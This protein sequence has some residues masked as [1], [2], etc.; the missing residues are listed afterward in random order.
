MG[1]LPITRRIGTLDTQV[2]QNA[3]FDSSFWINAYRSG[4]LLQGVDRY[5]LHFVPAV[6]RELKEEFAS[7]REFWRLAREDAM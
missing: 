5:E 2:N 4:L 1:E 6:A 3:T 7:G